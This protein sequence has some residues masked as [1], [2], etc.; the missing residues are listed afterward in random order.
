MNGHVFINHGT[1]EKMLNGR[2]IGLP[3]SYEIAVAKGRVAPIRGIGIFKS[4][5][6]LNPFY[7][8]TKLQSSII[9]EFIPIRFCSE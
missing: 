9:E 2:A 1:L 4:V 8:Q 5:P 3:S 7:G 6:D